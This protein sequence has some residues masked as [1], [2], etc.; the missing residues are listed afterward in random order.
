M[1]S[2]EHIP[3]N[4]V[5]K[6]FEELSEIKPSYDIPEQ[7]KYL[8]FPMDAISEEFMDPNYWEY[9]NKDKL[10]NIKFK[11]YDVLFARITPS[12]EN[13][14]G[15]LIRNLPDKIAY[16]STE[17]VVLSPKKE[18]IMPEYL[19][20]AT[21]LPR[22]RQ[23][24]TIL[25]EGATGRQRVPKYFFETHKILVPPLSEQQNIVA[26]L[27]NVDNL[28]RTT[29]R[30]IEKLQEWKRGLMQRL[31]T[32][33]IDHNEFQETKLGRIPKEWNIFKIKDI[34]QKKDG[35]KRGPWG[36]SI[37]KAFFVP[38]GYKIYEQKVVINNDFSLGNY[39][40]NEEKYKELSNFEIK[41]GDILMT[42]A[43]TIGLVE[44]VPE[45]IEPGIYNQ[46]LI[47]IR[48]NEKVQKEFLRYFLLSDLL[49]R[50][51]IGFSDGAALKNLASI[52]I[53]QNIPILLPPIIEQEKICDIMK[54]ADIQISTEEIYLTLLKKT[55]K[56]L[57]QV[58]LMGK[59]RV[60][61]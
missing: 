44:I 39:Y 42:A 51:L 2:Y 50:L 22:V 23:R 27:E 4:W 21:K 34:V 15:A 29:Q 48:N 54:D 12:T 53:L 49:Q 6:T 56:G 1:I 3:K 18:I 36:G 33:G 17:L 31:F 52:K 28:I 40:I 13:G 20:Y 9:R 41:M 11:N 25:M 26:I 14:K 32:E 57:M 55:K 16:G 46:A 61:L 37:K 58:L 8:F 59:K 19:F 38:N 5:L 43:G 10:T 35:L 7:D 47:R 30:L 24:A 60:P 45:G